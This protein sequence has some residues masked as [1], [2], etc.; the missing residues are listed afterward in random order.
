MKKKKKTQKKSSY[1]IL[2]LKYKTKTKHTHLK[3]CLY[4]NHLPQ[5]LKN[6][7]PTE[8]T[9]KRSPLE[10]LTESKNS[11]NKIP[12]LMTMTS[13]TYPLAQ[14]ILMRRY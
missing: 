11:W 3:R 1:P 6:L 9:T 14:K 2:V 8:T 13:T 7:Q 4:Y 12:M 5:P 10:A